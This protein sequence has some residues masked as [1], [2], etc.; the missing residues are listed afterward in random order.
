MHRYLQHGRWG[1]RAAV[2]VAAASAAI[3]VGGLPPNAA[4]TLAL[5]NA[6]GDGTNSIA[7]RVVAGVARFKV[8]VQAA[9]ALTTVPVS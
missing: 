5:W 1:R 4:F 6:T 2:A 8:P 9:F 3:A 7:D